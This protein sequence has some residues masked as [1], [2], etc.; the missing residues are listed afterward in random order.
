MYEWCL[1]FHREHGRSPTRKEATKRGLEI[2]ED[3]SFQASK[4]WLDK[5]S[6]KYQ[7]EF[8]PLKIVPPKLKKAGNSNSDSEPGSAKSKSDSS[9]FEGIS[10]LMQTMQMMQPQQQAT[11]PEPSHWNYSYPVAAQGNRQSPFDPENLKIS[12]FF[13][14]NAKKTN[15]EESNFMKGENFQ[16]PDQSGHYLPPVNNGFNYLYGFP[17]GYQPNYPATYQNNLDER[18]YP[19][20]INSN[21]LQSDIAR[22]LKSG[23]N[24]EMKHNI[25]NHMKFE[26][27]N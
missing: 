2:S 18:S 27:S 10:A 19:S 6:R 17:L 24:F 7:I 3:P 20:Y 8:T 14:T 9:G 5:F 4:G 15:V 1:I 16:V 21:Q 22:F 12:S 25:N 11:E 26:G 23:N 13:N